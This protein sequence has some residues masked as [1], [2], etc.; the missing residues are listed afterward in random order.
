MSN[1]IALPFCD[2]DLIAG[3]QRALFMLVKLTVFIN[4]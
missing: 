4:K 1:V 2:D 3:T